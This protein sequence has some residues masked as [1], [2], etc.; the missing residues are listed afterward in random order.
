MMAQEVFS[1]R[2]NASLRRTSM[3]NPGIFPLVARYWRYLL[4][5]TMGTECNQT[6]VL[7]C[8]YLRDIG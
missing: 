6:V 5:S 2:T 1:A 8:D 3:S 4:A 7:L